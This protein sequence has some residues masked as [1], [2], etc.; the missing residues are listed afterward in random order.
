[1]N[2]FCFDCWA[3]LC[4]ISHFAKTAVYY[5][6][7]GI[8]TDQDVNLQTISKVTQEIQYWLRLATVLHG[9]LKQSLLCVLHNKNNDPSY[10]GFS[11]DPSDL[12]RELSTNHKGTINKLVKD[13]VLKKDQIEVLLPTNGDNKTFSDAFDITLL[14]VLIINCTTLPPPQ[15]GWKQK[16][17]PDS[18]TGVAA[19]VIRGREWRNFLNHTDANVIDEAA[20]NLKWTEGIAIIQ[21]LGGSTRQMATLKTI[22]LDP[23]HE[24]VLKSLYNFNTKISAKQHKHDL[25]ITDLKTKVNN[26]ISPKQQKQEYEIADLK[27]KVDNDI[28]PKQ[29]KQEYEIA[30]LKTKV[31][32]DILPKQQK[33]EYEIADLKIDHELFFN[34]LE[35]IS[36]EL[37]QLKKMRDFNQSTVNTSNSNNLGIQNTLIK[38]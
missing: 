34:Q 15:D 16:T 2:N 8:T 37:E 1:M 21:G 10:K 33:Q 7:P 24:L 29:Q 13:R 22:S 20:F 31:D 5:L 11:E 3:E 9:P 18:D 38:K 32:N 35:A 30:D 36:K 19:N 27:T 12:Y 25:D 6:I 14:V 26:D 28:L 17:P 23:K 4:S